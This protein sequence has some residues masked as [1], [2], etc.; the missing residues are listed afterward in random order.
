MKC[1]LTLAATALLCIIGA[2]LAPAVIAPTAYG[3]MVTRLSTPAP[4]TR[5]PT[6]TTPAASDDT[7]PAA[8]VAAVTP[9]ADQATT[10]ATTAKQADHAM[11][12][13]LPKV[14]DGFEVF[15]LQTGTVLTSNNAGQQFAAMSV[16]KLL[17]ALDAL[18]R[19]NWLIPDGATQQQIRQM[20]A[21]SDDEIADGL[22]TAGGGPAIVT[23]MAGRLGLTGTQPPDDPGEWG[24]TLIT[25]RDM[26]TVYRYIAEQVPGPDRDLLLGALSGAPRIAADGFNQYFGIPDGMPHTT[27]A[28]KQGW[29]TSGSQA[30][31]DS[32][33]LVG[34]DLRYV[35]VVL[36][37][38]PANSYSTVPAAVTAGAGELAGLVGSAGS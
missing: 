17:I 30:V 24:D 11:H 3:S 31:M 36:A 7:A 29:G 5:A 27:W 16:V 37:S 6:I 22:W 35:V 19:D 4:T 26:V 1:L 9:P 23:R 10:A 32:T 25:P 12:A 13:V 18:A 38:A 2:G 33:G 15:D 14:Q 8:P 20:L 28:I 34:P 21:D